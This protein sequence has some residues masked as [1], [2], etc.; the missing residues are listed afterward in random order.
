M[1]VSCLKIKNIIGIGKSKREAEK[2]AA[3]KFL[4]KY[5]EMN[6]K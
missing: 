1:S 4:K 6:E 2:L 3:E 5:K